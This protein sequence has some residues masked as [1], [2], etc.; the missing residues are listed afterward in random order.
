[1]SRFRIAGK[2]RVKHSVPLGFRFDGRELQGLQGDSVASALLAN[3]IHPTGAS[4]KYHRQRG[5]VSAGPEEPGAL[6]DANRT[7][8]DDKGMFDRNTY[9]IMQELRQG[10][11]V[12]SQ[13]EW[14]CL[15]FDS[16][17]STPRD[18]HCD[19]LVVGSGPAGIA[20]AY[21]AVLAGA[22]VILVDENPEMGGYLLSEPGVQIDQASSWIW[23]SS[24]LAEL[25]ALGVR[26]MTRTTAIGYY[27]QNTVGLCERLLDHPDQPQSEVPRERLW[28]VRAA[29]VIL[30]QGAL[31][32][33]LVFE[34]S[35]RPGIMLAGSAQT[36]LHRYGVRVGD[37]AVVLTS[38]DSA[39]YAAFD[40][41]DHGTKIAAIIHIRDTVRDD[42]TQAA[43]SRGIEVLIGHTVTATSG[44]PHINSVRVDLEQGGRVGKAVNIACDCLLM[45]GGW[46]PSLHLFP[47]TKSGLFWDHARQ[48]FRPGQKPETCHIAGAGRG[49]WGYEAA[50]IDG[51]LVGRTSAKAV[52]FTVSPGTFRVENDRLGAGVSKK[53]VD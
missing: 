10:A 19:V 1:M 12:E 34:G 40:L 38:H 45:S 37:L 27:A 51:D 5:P 18:L 28:R 6:I 41:A 29:Q 7:V 42:L 4:F 11:I 52:G 33:P 21:S 48:E 50:L 9:A 47:N 30:A 22:S 35:D 15:S 36:Y 46:A 25:R 20:A 49:L 43:R 26:L 13:N 31:E 2:G 32:K 39:W 44:Q 16:E 17:R 23:L 53:A 14:P 3:G 8:G 24:R